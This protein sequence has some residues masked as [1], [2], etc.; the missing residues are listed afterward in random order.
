MRQAM[1]PERI[2]RPRSTGACYSGRNQL[3]TLV[4]IVSMRTTVALGR[5]RT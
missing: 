1:L 3:H 2:A 5:T 4:A